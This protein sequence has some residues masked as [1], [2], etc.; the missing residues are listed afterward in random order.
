MAEERIDTDV[1]DAIEEYLDDRADASLDGDP[2]EYRPNAA[3]SLLSRL[4]ISRTGVD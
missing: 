4:R 3:M 2:P 1:L